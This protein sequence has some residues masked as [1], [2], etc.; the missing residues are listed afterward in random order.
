MSFEGFNTGAIINN[1]AST[2][3]AAIV[4]AAGA[5]IWDKAATLD[6]RIEEANTK[7]RIQQEKLRVTQDILANKIARLEVADQERT[8]LDA[9][10]Q[11][12]DKSGQ[13]DAFNVFVRSLESGRTDALKASTNQIFLDY[14][15]AFEKV[16]E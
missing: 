14:K 5:I 1:V 16:V 6:E 4:I 10:A 11:V 12:Q 9:F 7:I 2:I 13:S 3:I 15:A 8:A